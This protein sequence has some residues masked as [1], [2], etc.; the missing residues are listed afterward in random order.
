MSDDAGVDG[1]A[2]DRQFLPPGHDLRIPANLVRDRDQSGQAMGGLF[3]NPV[4][5][6]V[7][8]A[9]NGEDAG[10]DRALAGYL[11]LSAQA[12]DDT[13]HD[14]SQPRMPRQDETRSSSGPSQSGV[15]Q[16]SQPGA[17]RWPDGRAP[18]APIG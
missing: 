15:R 3:A 7:C 18:F 13:P 9:M 2:G 10:Q 8:S 5:I 16:P 11:T 4:G 12:P 14:A 1:A 17:L 6:P